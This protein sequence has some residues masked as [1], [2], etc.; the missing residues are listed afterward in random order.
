MFSSLDPKDLATVIDAMQEKSVLEGEY[1]IKEGDHGDHLF[2][3]DEGTLE[4][5]KRVSN[6]EEKFI[7][8]YA[9][10]EGFGELALLYN[11]K[12][13]A[14]IRARTDCVLWMLDRDTFNNIVKESAVR[15]RRKY[16]EFLRDIKIL[17]DINDYERGKI[18]DA[19]KPGTFQ[20]NEFVISQGDMGNSFFFI[21]SGTAVALKTM[22]PDDDP[23]EVYDYS[24]GD[25]FGELALLSKNQKRSASIK[26]TSA[27]DVVE[28]DRDS[29]K[30]LCGP[31][32][33]ILKR[34]SQRY[35]QFVTN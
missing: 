27:L 30:R 6:T 33:S 3:V 2:V 13:Q 24:P 25:Y 14:S 28:L 11:T 23:I 7:K 12:R 19:L 18:A 5:S 20:A 34:N 4:C 31:L 8:N 16:E 10:G 15:K 29:F 21:E 26:A 22:N 17:Q 32:E 35:A 9:K 1:V